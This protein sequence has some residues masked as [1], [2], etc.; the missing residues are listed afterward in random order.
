MPMSH[1]AN[2]EHLQINELKHL[3]LAT[4]RIRPICVC[5]SMLHLKFDLLK[6]INELFTID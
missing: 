5:E 3:K 2:N 4:G 6:Q 1:W